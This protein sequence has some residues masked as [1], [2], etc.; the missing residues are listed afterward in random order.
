MFKFNRKIKK[1]K[2]MTYVELIVVLSIFATMS[3]VVIFNYG[4]FQAKVDIK[5]LASDI[6]LKIVEAQ[7]ASLS[8]K[9]PVQAPS[10]SPWKPSYGVYFDLSNSG[11]NKAFLYFVDLNQDGNYTDTS[12]CSL[13]GGSGECLDKITIAKSVYI[14]SINKCIGVNCASS[15]SI[16]D[17]LSVTFKRPDSRAIFK[18]NGVSMNDFDYVQITVSSP[19]SIIAKIKLYSSG[20]I[21]VN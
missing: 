8:G 7:K 9:I 21:Q 12:F 5:N 14:S 17:P 16:T 3:S 20:R 2:G 4:D 11:S 1:N 18:S 6:A 13:P 10:V 15:V 19:R